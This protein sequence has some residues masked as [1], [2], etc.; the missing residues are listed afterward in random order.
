MP[1]E[2][3]LTTERLVLDL[4]GEHDIEA[5]TEYRRLPEVARYQSWTTDYSS[6]DARA[7]VSSQPVGLPRPGQ[8][9][10]LAVRAVEV[11][12]RIL[13]GDVAIGADAIQPGTFELGITL[14]PRHQ[15]RGFAHEALS[16]VIEWLFD[17]HN[18][19]RILMHADA[20]N[21]PVL[22]VMRSLE[23]RHEGTAVEGDWFKGEWTS[24]ERFALLRRERPTL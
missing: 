3:S 11:D 16:A 21:A 4:L 18:A 22:R 14:H 1:S 9:I 7:L 8:W 10:Q 17:Q 6:E 23:L 5:F 24:L 15:G 12:Q 13:V 19:H 2:L 20:R